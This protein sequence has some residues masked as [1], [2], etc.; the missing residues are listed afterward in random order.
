M[1]ETGILSSKVTRH[2]V[3][4]V[5]ITALEIEAK[6]IVRRLKDR[7]V[8]RFED[9]DIRTYH[10]GTIPIEGTDR[11]YQV[12][13][14][15][16]PSM[17]K[18]P[19]ATAATDAI[20]RWNPQFVLMVGI[21]AGIPSSKDERELGDVIVADQVIGY[22]HAKVT[23]K[24]YEYRER[25][26]PVSTL[27]LDRVRNFWDTSWTEQIFTPRPTNAKRNKP[28]LHIGPVASGDKVVA[29]TEFRG[30]LTSRWP[31][32][33]AVEM[34]AEG[35]FSAVFDRPQIRNTLMIRGVCDLADERKDDAWQEY[36]ADNAAAFTVSFLRSGPVLPGTPAALVR[37][38]SNPFVY[39]RPVQP[40]EFVDR[41]RDLSTVFNRL[42]N[43][44]S[45][46]IVGEPHIGK[47]SLLKRL[48]DKET[49]LRYLGNGIQELVFS[50][51][52]LHYISNDFS[53]NVF[54]ER[55]IKPLRKLS[56]HDDITWRLAKANYSGDSLET[57]FECLYERGQQLV[58]LLDEF[59]LLL[60]HQ[61]FR[62]FSF[63]AMLRAVDAS[64]GLSL[65]LASR[66]ALEELEDWVRKLPA[67]GGSPVFNYLTEVRLLPFDKKDINTLLNQAGDIFS[68][69]DRLFIRFMAG[70]HPY[71]V[72][73]MAA[74]LWETTGEP[75]YTRAAELYYSRTSSHFDYL[76]RTLD[77]CTRTTA[78]VL[79]LIELGRYKL[80]DD[81]DYSEIQDLSNLGARLRD[82]ASSRYKTTQVGALPLEIG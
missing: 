63:Y 43:G 52:N 10:S 25:E 65:V 22:E 44:E 46:A 76:W 70:R 79:G 32:L 48:A 27:L 57:F 20:A 68:F 58:V 75:R 78:V 72:Q 37:S 73:A 12:V 59:D 16:L 6:A 82:L 21:A 4:F 23:E 14:V 74:I 69:D 2:E 17:G 53:P 54:W 77:D 34:E 81:F 36:A 64:R 7:T 5:I 42:R 40:D 49:Q 28:K 1:V 9:K 3:D 47:T 61:N 51:L 30:Q 80:G 26:Y 38:N 24:G 19:A 60:G 35:V 18:L 56:S 39:G 45:T 67:S 71:L 31:K 62:E 55:A 13:V 15:L 8:K 11:A 41:E 33:V 50:T 29:S 66:L